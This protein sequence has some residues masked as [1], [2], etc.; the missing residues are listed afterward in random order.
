MERLSAFLLRVL[1][2]W[3]WVCH[4]WLLMVRHVSS[5][6][7][8]VRVLIMNGCWILSNAF[9]VFI[10]IIMW[11]LTPFVNV[12]YDIDLCMLSHPCGIRDES[13][14]VM[15][16]FVCFLVFFSFYYSVLS[17]SAVQQSDPIIHIC[18]FFFL[19]YPSSF[20]IT[21]VTG[22]SSL[23]CIAGSHYLSTPDAVVCI[24][25]PQIPVHPIP[26]PSPLATTSLFSMSMSLFIFWR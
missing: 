4:K 3:L 14:L 23:C 19:H 2:Y 16:F 15:M 20:S 1:Y 9:S 17:I 6:C 12:V 10:E 5:I 11:V 18:T 24:Y 26:S 8:V 7:T 13:H 21:S 25:Q 22:Y